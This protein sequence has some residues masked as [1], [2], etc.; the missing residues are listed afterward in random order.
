[1]FL[2]IKKT[3]EYGIYSGANEVVTMVAY[4]AGLQ[5]TGMIRQPIQAIKGKCIKGKCITTGNIYI[6]AYYLVVTIYDELCPLA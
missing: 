3:P 2:V 1:M 6:A 5:P 4:Y